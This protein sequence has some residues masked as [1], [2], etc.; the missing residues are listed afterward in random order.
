MFANV[1]S[2]ATTLPPGSRSSQSGRRS[3]SYLLEPSS[4]LHASPCGPGYLLAPSLT[5]VPTSTREA[6][7]GGEA[8]V[9][10]DVARPETAAGK[11]RAI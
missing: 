4:N 10:P 6:L 7:S 8:P 9:L 1:R 2:P 11:Q 3:P 5:L